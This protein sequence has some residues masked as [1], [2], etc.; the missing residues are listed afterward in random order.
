V[1]E[2]VGPRPGSEPEGPG[3]SKP[4]L[5]GVGTTFL[6]GG[7]YVRTVIDVANERG[8]VV[9][10]I[11]GR[12]NHGARDTLTLFLTADGAKEV[13]PM[14]VEAAEACP[15]DWERYRREHP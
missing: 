10:D 5:A 11:Q 3:F 1:S 15:G 12:W 13:G 6:F 8:L 9:L 2:G 4:Y 14:L 7:A